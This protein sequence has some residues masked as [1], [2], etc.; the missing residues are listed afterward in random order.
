MK[1]SP[2]QRLWRVLWTPVR[3]EAYRHET[4]WFRAVCRAPH[5]QARVLERCLAQ[6]AGSDFA[7][8][9]R[10]DRVRT[11]EDLRAAVPVAGYERAAPYIERLQAGDA[12]ALFAPGTRVHMFALTSGTTGRP[13]M[14]PVTD[15]FLRAYRRGWHVYGV[16]ALDGNAGA[17][18]ARI[19]QVVSRWDERRTPSGLYAGAMSGFSAYVQRGAVRWLMAVPPEAGCAADTETK[20]YLAC[21][22]G[23]RHR[24]VLPITANP[25]TLLGLA[26]A[27]DRRK[28]DLVRDL[29]DGTL[30][31]DL[32]LEA[33]PRAVIERRLRPAPRRA[34]ALEAIIASRGRLYPKDAWELPLIGTWKGGTL[35]LYLRDMPRYF[36]DAPIR[37]IGLIASEGRL[38]VPI[39]TEGCEGVLEVTGTVFEFMPPEEAGKDDPRTVLPHETEVGGR[40]F[41]VLTAPSGLFRYDI[42]DVVEVTG[43]IGPTPLIRFLNKGEH[44]ANLTGEKVTEFQVVSAVNGVVAR[45]GLPVGSYCLCP[46]WDAPPYYS[47]LVEEGA[48]SG[49]TARVLAR[50]ADAALQELNLEFEGRRTSGRL[51]P[52]RVKTIPAGAWDAFDREA[53]AARSG[54][55]EQYKHKFLS[56]DVDFDRRFAVTASYGPG[57]RSDL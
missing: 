22:L 11:I 57:G 56:S 54:R 38:S 39:R 36:G 48:V 8:D 4:A 14:V 17:F 47:L 12:G 24:R 50:E 23:L 34:R 43:R 35:G 13:K 53:V 46:T 7:R 44:V 18:G 42:S 6:V 29:R 15:L 52:I 25:S 3:L 2:A 19:L 9:M 16:H 28:E 32:A 26:Q 10:L 31:K 40:Y 21:R 51:G 1:T 30:K 41:L 37:D 33:P 49:K 45:L 20:Y 5:A 27:M 55:I